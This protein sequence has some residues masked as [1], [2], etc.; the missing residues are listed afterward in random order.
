LYFPVFLLFT[1]GQ[2][3]G[4]TE[5]YAIGTTTIGDVRTACHWR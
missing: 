2:K 3:G 5:K 4:M 1:I